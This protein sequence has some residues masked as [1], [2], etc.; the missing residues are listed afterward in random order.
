MQTT[1]IS[2]VG[3]DPAH[4]AGGRRDSIATLFDGA[5]VRRLAPGRHIYHDGEER[6]HLFMIESGQVT[7]YRTQEDGRRHVLGFPGR[8]DVIGLGAASSYAHSAITSTAGIVR[9]ISTEQLE[10]RIAEEPGLGLALFRLLNARLEEEQTRSATLLTWSATERVAGFLLDCAAEASAN[11]GDPREVRLTVTRSTIADYL[12]TTQETISRLMA[13]LRES[14]IVGYSHPACIR[15]LDLKSLARL[16]GPAEALGRH[17][18]EA[19]C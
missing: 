7:L 18:G 9:W 10:R 4:P 11:G 14:H 3:R 5:A 15:L 17:R 19:L 12:G 8:G 13:R 16:A 2:Q 6:S 1:A